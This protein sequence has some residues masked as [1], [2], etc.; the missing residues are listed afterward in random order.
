MSAMIAFF[1]SLAL[2]FGPGFHADS[3]PAGNLANYPFPEFKE[4]KAPSG[5][6]PFYISHL[7]R[8][9]SRYDITKG[10]DIYEDFFRLFT[11]A[12][13]TGNLT[14]QGKAFLEDIRPLYA[15]TRG[16]AGYLTDNGKR[17]LRRIAE[18]VYR[19][20]PAVFKGKTR[21]EAVST[22][23]DRTVQTMETFCGALDSLDS[24]FSLHVSDAADALFCWD[25]SKP[26]YTVADDAY[27]HSFS[28]APWAAGYAS[29]LCAPLEK[30]DPTAR[31]FSSAPD[32]LKPEKFLKDLYFVC[33][34]DL[35]R[36]PGSTLLQTYMTEEELRSVWG[37]LNYRYYHIFGQSDADRGRHWKLMYPLLQEMLERADE[38]IRSG[39]CALRLRFA[40][41]SQL[42]PLLVLM[43]DSRFA[44]KAPEYAAVDAYY[45][46]G[47]AP[48]ASHL[49]FVFYRNK[50]GDILVRLLMNDEDLVLPLQTTGGVFYSWT[51]L[52]GFLIERVDA[53]KT[54]LKDGEPEAETL[55]QAPAYNVQGCAV[56]KD[57]LFSMFDKGMCAVYDL[58]SR[59]LL[60]QF[61]LGSAAEDNHANVAFFGPCYYQEGDAFP[62][63]YVSQAKG[64]RLLFVE[65]I[66]TDAEGVP[67][68]ARTVQRIHY[69][70]SQ[71]ISRL[72][73]VDDTH[74]ERIYC[75]GN[76][77]GNH[78]PGNRIAIEEFPFPAF[79]ASVPDLT[80]TEAE[81]IRRFYFDELLPSG[82]RGPQDNTLQ[83]AMIHD[84]IFFLPIGS[85]KKYPAELFYAALDGSRYAGLDIT[86]AFPYEM[87][88]M[89]FWKGRVIVPCNDLF[90]KVSFLAA[91]SWED[92]LDA[93]KKR[94][95]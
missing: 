36:N 1:V 20:F 30:E 88:D 12:D 47:F 92:L 57:C 77:V 49:L 3:Y 14:P 82:M 8:H 26:F 17:D 45:D 22:G 15:A 35:C 18:N 70:P 11:E 27:I 2:A 79:D 51:A 56:W 38:D 5:Y 76:T 48:M 33:T 73:M 63:L 54:Q 42:D 53:A 29:R 34:T 87:E 68:G 6:K 95:P 16:R 23:L 62:L 40:H 83:G 65:R 50:K 66:L 46:W 85:G 4:V 39:E 13:S 59:T 9:G 80:L 58:A 37:A 10:A 93:M 86:D 75:Y 69:E 55:M 72:W 31:F 24:S 43:G 25:Y 67:V 94:K 32:G 71:R 78:K 64:E 89:A 91:F 7:S 61:P 52:R 84:G 81:R 60:S 21:A 44:A 41:D 19:R 74:P 28:L 90:K